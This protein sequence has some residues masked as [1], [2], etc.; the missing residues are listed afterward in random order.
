[1][2]IRLHKAL[3]RIFSLPSVCVTSAYYW[4]MSTLKKQALNYLKHSVGWLFVA[5]YKQHPSN[6]SQLV[7]RVDILVLGGRNRFPNSVCSTKRHLTNLHSKYYY[8]HPNGHLYW[9]IK[10]KEER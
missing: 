6:P 4:R 10:G 8:M 7:V 1:M 2:E 3:S 9:W 5:G